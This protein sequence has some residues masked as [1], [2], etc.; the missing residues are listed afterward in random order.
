LSGAVL[1]VEAE[2]FHITNQ[3]S[4][5]TPVEL[6]T[7]S[8]SGVS[9]VPVRE[10]R[11]NPPVRLGLQRRAQS[12][13]RR[14]FVRGLRRFVV[15]VIADLAS[16]YVMRALVRAVRDDAVLGQTVS[17]GVSA[18]VPA[19]ILNGWQF[20]AALF[21]G[22]VILGT[23]GP[24][25]ARRDAKQLFLAC[26]LATA[27][28]LWMSLWTHGIEQF[29]LQYTV[30]TLLVWLGLLAERQ[31]LHSIVVRISARPHDVLTTLFV[32]PAE[33][34]KETAA[35]PAF[36]ADSEYR[37]I[38]FV[39]THIP[40]APSALGH[41]VDFAGVLH[42]SSAEA[43]VVC[44]YLTDARFHDVVD[45]ALTAGC[46]VLAVPRSIAIA[47]V[48]PKLVWR[49]EQPL[50]ELTTPTL[51]GGQ[52]IAKR[53][54]DL[55]GASVGLILATPILLIVAALVKVDSRGSVLFRQNRVGRGGRLFKI[56][57][58]RTMVAGAEE[59][60]DELMGRSIYPDRRLFKIVGDPRVT[61]L[62][63]W[64]RRTSLDELPQLFNVLKGDM[65]LVGPRPPIPSEVDL[66]EAHH[67]ARF[68]VKPGI[69]G[70]WQVAG[71]N[72]ITDFEQIVALETRYI[73]DWSLLSD[74]GILF[75]TV[76][77]VLQM[78]GAV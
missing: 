44:G 12:N 53:C 19:G 23:Y 16:F 59:R 66:Y 39:D 31:L 15:L 18:L 64:L 69:T 42:D 28:P 45:A 60:R 49:R 14:Y 72:R 8:R 56:Y 74:I 75:R 67:Y 35:S 24:G 71:R 22:L 25:D 38:G 5:S 13:F 40:P 52:L 27:L 77:V 17:A 73:R 55:M 46:K 58:F 32:G 47:G 20:A 29:A 6:P 62:G 37:P 48:E 7:P 78:R 76:S 41:I 9:R 57:K 43:V 65:S 68:D 54:V 4:E 51:R 1:A 50:V 33:A 26:A 34:C 61:R 10:R 36:A 63:S 11:R 21:V 70:P 30:T 3:Q 2:P